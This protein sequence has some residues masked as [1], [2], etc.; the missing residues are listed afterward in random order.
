M[1]SSGHGAY[2]H[3]HHIVWIPKFRKRILKGALKESVEKR[4]FEIQRFHPDI[5]I[6]KYSIQKNHV[7]LV[8]VIPPRYYYFDV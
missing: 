8:I 6:E 7:Q 1:I 5:K 4:L 3:R 2:H